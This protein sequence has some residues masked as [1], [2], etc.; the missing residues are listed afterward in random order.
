MFPPHNC[1]VNIFYN[2]VSGEK[3]QERE[4]EVK[5]KEQM[6]FCLWS[7]IQIQIWSLY[8]NLDSL[9]RKCPL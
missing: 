1:L 6:W 4:D 5:T 3:A 8:L 7:P 9:E 2:R